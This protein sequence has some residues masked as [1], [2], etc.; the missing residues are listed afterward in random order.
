VLATVSLHTQETQRLRRIVIQ[1]GG[2]R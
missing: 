1:I 2:L